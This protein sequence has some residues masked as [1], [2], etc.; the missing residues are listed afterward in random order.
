[1]IFDNPRFQPIEKHA[2]CIEPRDAQVFVPLG[3][4]GEA[5]DRQVVEAGNGRL[6]VAGAL[7]GVGAVGLV[8]TVSLL[9][10]LLNWGLS[11]LDRRKHV[12][13][14]PFVADQVT[15]VAPLV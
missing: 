8:A 14:Q 11:F 3:H 2:Q 4:R 7:L 9:A 1:M 13:I 10:S 15:E 12:L 6:M 5:G